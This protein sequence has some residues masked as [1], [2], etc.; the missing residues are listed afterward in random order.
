MAVTALASATAT[1]I[2]DATHA[3]VT[4]V[5]AGTTVHDQATVAGQSGLPA[6]SG[7]VTFSWFTNGTCSAPAAA[8]SAPVALDATG[9]ADAVGFPQTPSTGGSFAFQAVYSGDG[10]YTG[11]TG[12]CEPLTVTSEQDI[13]VPPPTELPATGSNPFKLAIAALTL[14]GLGATFVLMGPLIDR[15]KNRSSRA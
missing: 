15:R 14:V 12:P 8:T 5:P 13:A 9:V 6:P 1:V 3:T 10:T 11:S 4:S 2:H 7:T